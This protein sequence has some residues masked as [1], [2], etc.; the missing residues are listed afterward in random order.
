MQE[1]GIA[2]QPDYRKRG[3]R[4]RLYSRFVID[5]LMPFIVSNFRVQTAS[6]NNAIGGFSLGGLSALD[7][8]WHHPE[9][10][11]R[12]G[13]FSGSLWWRSR[14][15][16]EGFDENK[17]RI[18]HQ[19][20]RSGEHKTGLRFWLE[21]GTLDEHADRNHNGIIDSIDDTLDLI[22]E[23]V[24]KGY[25]PYYDIEYC[26]IKNGKHNQHTWAKAMPQFLKWAFGKP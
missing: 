17:H 20:I 9:W 23:L 5:E 21:A 24:K 22:S 7:I 2:A 4:A 12:I 19:M 6:A 16:E 15:Y 11:Q 14:G 3:S 10:F 1:Y 8:G 25:R 26:E 13:I 18:A